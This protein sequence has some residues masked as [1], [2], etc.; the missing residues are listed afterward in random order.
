[1]GTN[2]RRL[3]E[4]G[5]VL[6]NDALKRWN[7]RMMVTIHFPG[8][9]RIWSCDFTARGLALRPGV[10]ERPNFFLE[11]TATDL[12]AVQRGLIW[13]QFDITGYRCYHTLYRVREEGIAYPRLPSQFHRTIEE[14]SGQGDVPSP[15]DVFAVLWEPSTDA[16]IE[17]LVDLSLGAAAAPLRMSATSSH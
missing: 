11:V 7:A 9:P 10:I 13:G 8:G 16:F 6:L 12:H 17:R 4:D 14:E 2:N 1:V 5:F 15:F 3:A